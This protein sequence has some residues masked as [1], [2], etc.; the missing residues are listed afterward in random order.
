MLSI[1]SLEGKSDRAD[2]WIT[3]IAGG[4]IA[5]LGLVVALVARFQEA[6]PNWIVFIASILVGV[7]AVWATIAVTARRFRDRGDTPWMTLLLAVPILGEL[8][9]LVVCGFLAN[10]SRSR[11]K[12]VMRRVTHGLE[13]ESAGR[14]DARHPAP[15]PESKSDGG[16]D[17]QPIPKGRSQ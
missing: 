17:P 6:G 8:W 4:V 5:Q 9:V 7:T 15:V 1:L 2:W 3:T 11:R 14:G 10:P 13:T 16:E 12:V